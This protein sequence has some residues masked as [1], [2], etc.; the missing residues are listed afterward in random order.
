MLEGQNH[1]LYKGKISELENSN[2][3]KQYFLFPLIKKIKD[4]DRTEKIQMS[5]F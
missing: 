2:Y 3:Y 4:Y 5:K 1:S